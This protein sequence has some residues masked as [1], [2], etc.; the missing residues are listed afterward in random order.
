MT[1]VKAGTKM[2]YVSV[3]SAEVDSSWIANHYAGLLTTFEKIT[4][5][6]LDAEDAVTLTS[7]AGISFELEA[8]NVDTEITTI[9]FVANE[10]EW[11][12]SNLI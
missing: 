10:D 2:A 11:S 12:N 4:G 3:M 1:R 7:E 9:G 5:D 6:P 8:P